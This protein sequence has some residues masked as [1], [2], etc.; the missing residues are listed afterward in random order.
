MMKLNKI[1]SYPISVIFY[2]LF[3]L[4]LV[5]FHPVQWICF[6]VFG[7]QAHKK[8]V[9]YFNWTLMRCMHALGTTFHIDINK[10]IPT[11]VPIIIVSNHQSMWEIAP[12]SWFLRK[13]HPKFISKEE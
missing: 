11:N 9:D 3:G 2:L 12:I 8:S 6:N 1:L 10:D 5:V 7:Y 4:T 13:Y